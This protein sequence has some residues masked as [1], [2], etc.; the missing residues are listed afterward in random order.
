M[1]VGGSP[2]LSRW[3]PGS[4]SPSYPFYILQSAS[5]RLD[6]HNLSGIV[7]VFRLISLYLE[8]YNK[9]AVE[10][11]RA[12]QPQEPQGGVSNIS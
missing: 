12:N 1:P 3:R 5:G 11:C 8:A 10:C 9:T 6:G 2:V 7:E 4:R